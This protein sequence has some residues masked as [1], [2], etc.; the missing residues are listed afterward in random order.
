M[1]IVNTVV[2]VKSGF[3]LGDREVALALAAFGAGSM[4]AALAL[5]RLLERVPDRGRCWPAP[6]SLR[7]MLIGSACRPASLMPLW[8][9]LGLGYSLAQTPRAAAAAFGAS[10]RSARALRRAVR[11]VTRLLAGHLSTRGMAGRRGGARPHLP[12]PRGARCGR[13]RCGASAVAAARSRGGR[14][15]SPRPAVGRPSSRRRRPGAGR[16]LPPPPC[17][18]R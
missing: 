8:F 10:R 16:R 7:W 14:A 3:G 6:A 18:R 4:V 15:R 5:P 2:L 13:A 12:G 1:V 11:A 17:L 9:V